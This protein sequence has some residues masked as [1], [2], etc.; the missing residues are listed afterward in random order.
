M[1]KVRILGP[2]ERLEEVLDAL[3]DLGLVHL[4]EP[5]PR[6]SLRAPDLEEE[7]RHVRL[8]E[9]ALD[10]IENVLNRLP[11]TR[12]DRSFPDPD[13]EDR[14][15]ARWIRLARRSRRTIE[16]LEEEESRLVEERAGLERYTRF[17]EAFE[18][19]TPPEAGLRDGRAF[20]LVL[21][22]AAVENLE[23]LESSLREAIGPQFEIL[24]TATEG[25]ELAVV[26]LVPRDQAGGVERILAT[27]GVEELPLAETLG[28]ATLGE[29][30]PDLRRRLGEIE[31]HLAG[32][33]DERRGLA[34]RHGNDLA[35]ARAVLRDRLAGIEARRH[36][37]ETDRAFVLEGW[38]PTRATPRLESRLAESFDGTVEVERIATEAWAGEAAPVVLSNPRMFRPFETIVRLFPL[39]HYGTIDP[40]PFVAVFFPMFFG[41]ILGDVGYGLVLGFLAIVFRLRSEPDS[42]L[43]SVA[44]IAGACS[45][46]TIA[47]GALYG[48]VFGD[49]ARRAI[50]LEP[51]FDR[52]EALV[53]FLGFAVALGFVHVLLGLV[54]GAINSMRLD[55]RQSLGRGLS[56]VV[57]IL[58]AVALLAAVRI[59]PGSFFTPAV[60]AL[61]VAFPVLVVVEG[62]L[63]PVEILSTIGNVLSYARIMA[64][65]TASVV[66]AIVANRLVGALGG[67][68]V[69]VLFGLLFHLVNFALGVFGPTIH[70]LRLHYVEFFGKFYSPGGVRYRPFAHWRPDE[71]AGTTQPQPERSR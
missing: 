67:A 66:M 37:L 59:L 33:E 68:V 42:L 19:I 23:R 31:R 49:L 15:L 18:S 38:L 46:F 12:P 8:F 26:L 63:A 47:F 55:P 25:G 14:D 51:I 50:G 45:V 7:R 1:D 3:Q 48:E 54:L 32:I 41:I 5:R 11:G 17:F 4:A 64:L 30:I 44:G 57:L 9:R 22:S 2:A 24:S 39:P 29:A 56:A 10:D 16:R 28:T 36:V 27:T 53:P 6:G 52:E 60:V 69:G 65:G 62:F 20:H 70:A 40:T 34:R 61:L 21:R 71:P 35:R 58:I 43:R 13:V